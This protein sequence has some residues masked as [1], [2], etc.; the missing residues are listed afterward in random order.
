MN[1]YFE[2]GAG[3]VASA[4]AFLCFLCFF[5][6]AVLAGAGAS[7]AG[8]AAGVAA[9]AAGVA[10]KAETANRLATKADSKVFIL[11]PIKFK[12]R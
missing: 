9:G 12:L 3:A 10:A 6:A 1:S 4:A 7:T 11:D 2:A 8:V 5:G